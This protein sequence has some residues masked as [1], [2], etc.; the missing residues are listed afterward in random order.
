MGNR[1]TKLQMI[2][3]HTAQ[4]HS[5]IARQLEIIEALPLPGYPT[6]GAERQ[7]AHLKQYQK[8]HEADLA[9]L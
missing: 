2:Q 4:G 6:E 1:E 8:I 3:R 9:R 7:L 5:H